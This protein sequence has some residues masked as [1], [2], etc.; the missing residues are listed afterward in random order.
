MNNDFAEFGGKTFI[1]VPPL[2][3]VLM[4]P[5]VKL[6]GSPE[7]FRDGQFILWLA[8]IGPAVLLLVLE[9]LRRTGRSPR[10]ELENVALSLLFAFGTVYFFTAVEGT[11]WFAA[12]VV[13]VTCHGAL[14][15][16]ARFNGLDQGLFFPGLYFRFDQIP[17]TFL[18]NLAPSRNASIPG[19]RWGIWSLRQREPN[20]LSVKPE[21][22]GRISCLCEYP[23]TNCRRASQNS[24]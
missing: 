17:H 13:G 18:C 16:T 11:V 2:P 14:T 19:I 20:S 23:G 24:S 15:K 10:T 5:F 4:L 21:Q 12:M 7:N 1:S 9:K 3:A 8:G 22:R 6:A